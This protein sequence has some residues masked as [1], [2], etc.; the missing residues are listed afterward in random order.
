[1]VNAE[2]ISKP[3]FRSGISLHKLADGSM[4]LGRVDTEDAILVRQGEALYAVGA[5]CTHYHGPLADGL[6]VED[7][8]RCPWHHACFSLRTGEALSA[9]ALDALPGWRVERVGDT[10]F[11][12]E[13]LSEADPE[14]ARRLPKSPSVPDSVVIVGGGGAGLA[15]ADML[16]REGYDGAADYDQCRHFR[17]V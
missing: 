16:R 12:R 9:P 15:A 8:V 4:V 6:I 13:K 7:T 3:D 2:P 11:V 10:V 14:N 1:M 5:H 17:S